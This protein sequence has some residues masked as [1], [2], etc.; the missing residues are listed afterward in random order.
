MANLDYQEIIERRRAL[1]IDP[2]KSLADVGFEGPWVTPY[3]ITSNSPTGPVLVALHWLD[4]ASI[5]AEQ[6]T[7]QRFGYLPGIRFNAVIDAAL[8]RTSLRRSDIYVTQ[9]FHLIPRTRSEQIEPWAIRRSFDEVTRFELDG[10][11]VIALGATAAREC[12]RH[13]IE[14][15]AVC[16]P[17]RRG[18]INEKNAAEIATAIAALGVS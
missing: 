5:V 15:I 1:K 10:R 11:R 14:H 4:E 16:H 7:L 12:A 3:Q 9:A 8:E 17:S 18:F 2:F 13:N 6:T